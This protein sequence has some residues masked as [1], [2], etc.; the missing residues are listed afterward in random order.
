MLKTN[1]DVYTYR[2]TTRISKDDIECERFKNAI[3]TAL[4]N[5]PVFQTVVDEQ[6][7]QHYD[8][9]IDP[10]HGQYC[11]I[12]VEEKGEYV[13][14]SSTTNRIL[15][16]AISTQILIEDI[17]RAYEGL[18]LA[19]DHYYD[20][21]AQVEADKHSERYAADK[22]WLEQHFGTITCPVHPK[23]D[24][25]L[26]DL[27]HATEGV[28]EVDYTDM[29][30]ALDRLGEKKLVSLTALF[31]LASALAMMEYN[32][33]NESALTWAYDGR[34]TEDEQRIYG[35]M[36]RDIPFRISRV[37]DGGSQASRDELLLATRKAM[38]EGIKHSSYP[39]TLTAPHTEIWN[40]ALNVLVQPAPEATAATLP[41]SIE[42]L[43]IDKQQDNAYALLDVEIYETKPNV[44]LV[45]RYSA[46]HYK[47]ESMQKFAALV[48][49]Y[50]EWLTA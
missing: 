18:P 22:Q 48:R 11:H 23:T 9:H 17:V 15:G 36:H 31:S 12:E 26:H 38:R 27:E 40:Y 42:M 33:T 2:A 8:K 6:G 29:R 1:P 44:T 7:L 20:Y 41:I 14:V 25:P 46:T 30:D 32:G 47:E 13:Y 4:R 34:E 10:M 45:F 37:A 49:K 3:V 21:L 5:H 24:V 39:L 19:E 28:L 50:A 35:S 16:D 43:P